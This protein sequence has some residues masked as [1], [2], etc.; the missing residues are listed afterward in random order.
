MI[1][2]LPLVLLVGCAGLQQY[3]ESG[4]TGEILLEEAVDT[5]GYTLGLMAAEKPEFRAQVEH[6]YQEIATQG[7]T[8]AVVN[9]GLQQL[10]DQ[11]IAYQVLAYKMARIVRLAG[12]QIDAE[13]NITELGNINTGMLEIGKQGY[14]TALQNAGAV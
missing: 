2:I 10:M 1:F 6:Y 9:A 3:I 12:G 14:L 13:G 8:V 4:T 11:G 5:A 7:L